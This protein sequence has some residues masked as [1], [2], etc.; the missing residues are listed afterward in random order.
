MSRNGEMTYCEKCGEK[1]TTSWKVSWTL[2]GEGNIDTVYYQN[3][4]V[5]LYCNLTNG[6]DFTEGPVCQ[7]CREDREE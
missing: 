1:F 5:S 2:P 6:E 4:A 7:T 3:G